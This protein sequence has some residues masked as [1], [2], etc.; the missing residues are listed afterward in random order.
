MAKRKP[1]AP[2]TE[3]TPFLIPAEAAELLR[4]DE[5]TLANWRCSRRGPAFM[6][7]GGRVVYSEQALLAWAAAQS[8][9]VAG[10]SQA[11]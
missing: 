1:R 11:A 9:L 7:L 4:L 10:E 5:R 8:R 6:K 2:R 3:G